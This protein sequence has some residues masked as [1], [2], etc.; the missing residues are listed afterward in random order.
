M[1]ATLANSEYAG[2]VVNF[3]VQ[4]R[5]GPARQEYE[6]AHWDDTYMLH[7]INIPR[8]A[9][10]TA[11]N[12]DKQAAK[13]QQAFASKQALADRLVWPASEPSLLN[14]YSIHYPDS[15]LRLARA[16]G[17]AEG[18]SPEPRGRPAAF[19]L[20]GQFAGCDPASA[21]TA[22]GRCCG[23]T[24][25]KSATFTRARLPEC[26]NE[27]GAP[28]QSTQNSGLLPP[29]R[30]ALAPRP[31]GLFAGNPLMFY[32]LR[33]SMANSR[34][35]KQTRGILETPPMPVVP[36]PLCV[37]SMVSNSDVQM[38]LL[39][40]KSFY[41]KLGRGQ[42]V[43][44]VDRDMPV[45]ARTLLSTH[46]PGIQFQVLE[47][48]DVGPCQRG[49]TWERLVYLLGRTRD[50]YVIQLDCDTL[51]FGDDMHEVLDCVAANRA[52]TLSGG[53]RE[54]VSLPEAARRARAITHPNVGMAA[55]SLFDRYPGAE[56]LRYVRGS[57]G[58][59]GF[60]RG[61]FGRAQIEDFHVQ[62]ER[63]LPERW[64]EWGTEQCASNFAVANSPDALVLPF[65]K[66]ANF[67]HHHDDTQSSFLHFIGAYRYDDDLFA[68]HG[69]R[70][71]E[72]LEAR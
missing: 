33:K 42:L 39:S 65:P 44:V 15:L 66:Y 47:D 46:F 63:L 64:T 20:G 48:I 49:G 7:G 68:K 34:F 36:G 72:G 16:E 26:C 3:S 51:F 22:L 38:Y 58:F 40:M 13:L 10:H 19:G 2:R 37:V 29:A 60:A 35:Y 70:L 4:D 21:L 32:K 54:I 59:A 61:G 71:I 5:G 57:S 56:K 41:R 55:D 23:T 11:A 43:V 62:M 28:A 9:V 18:K 27:M 17:V 45:S 31:S 8:V 52:F 53:E 25:L 24:G 12:L 30:L 14:R 69:Q 6:G 67:D 1:E 50:E